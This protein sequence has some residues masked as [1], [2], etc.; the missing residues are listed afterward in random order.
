M[1][2]VGVPFGG[3]DKCICSADNEVVFRRLDLCLEDFLD[4]TEAAVFMVWSKSHPE[5]PGLSCTIKNN[6]KTN[7]N[8]AYL[9]YLNNIRKENQFN[10][11]HT[12]K[13]F[14]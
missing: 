5:S 6:Y 9:K 3:G 14:L 11:Q 4:E 7:V 12:Y 1:T 10:F 8:H 13:S 2:R